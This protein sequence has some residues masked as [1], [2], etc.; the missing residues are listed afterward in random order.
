[1]KEKIWTKNCFD[2]NKIQCYADKYKL[3]RAIKNNTRCD[4]CARKSENNY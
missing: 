3:K 4:F 1:M 2:C